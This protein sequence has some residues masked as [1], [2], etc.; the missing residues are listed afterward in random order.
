MLLENKNITKEIMH[1]SSE[2]NYAQISTSQQIFEKE[3]K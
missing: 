2:R 3:N 1:R